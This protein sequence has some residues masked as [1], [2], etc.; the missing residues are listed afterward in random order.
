M[1]GC[2]FRKGQV[3][4]APAD[5]LLTP[6]RLTILPRAAIRH[7]RA[8]ASGNATRRSA[9]RSGLKSIETQIDRL[10]SAVA[11]G[12][13]PN[14][15][16]LRKKMDDLNGRRDESLNLLRALDN[17]LP[18]FRQS[19]S[20]Q[21][22]A[23]IAKN[24]KQRLLEAPQALQKRYVHGLVSEIVVDREKAVI[25]G[26]REA[27]A[28]AVSAPDK[29]GGVLG[30]VREWRSAQ[31]GRHAAPCASQVLEKFF[32]GCTPEFPVYQGKSREFFDIWT[33]EAETAT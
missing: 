20:K 17:E 16:S 13:V 22:A 3:I 9:L 24:L 25:L 23:N 26:P 19:L 14:V 28:A 4:T 33:G 21:Q 8:I 5:Q 2:S 12:S 10:L 31:S 32:E 1:P 7:R 27:L 18:K 29:L 30:S 15:S 11:E 6:D